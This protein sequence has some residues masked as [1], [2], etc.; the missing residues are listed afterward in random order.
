VV[1]N[2]SSIRLERNGKPGTFKGELLCESEMCD[3]AL[4]TVFNDA[5]WEDLPI[6]EFADEVPNLG[7]AVLAVGYP[8]GNKSVTVTR[9][10]VSTVCLKD[11]SLTGLNPRLMCVQIDAA[12]NPGNSGGP[13]ISIDSKKIIG[14]AFSHRVNASLMSFIISVPVLHMFLAAYDRDQRKNFGCLPETGFVCDEL[15]NV[16]HR[17]LALGNKFCAD[18]FYGC[19]V[20][21]VNKFSPSSELVNVGDVL[22]EVEGCRV[23]EN[24]EVFFRNQEWLPYDWLITK[25]SFGE[26]V[27]IKLLR[28][29]PSAGS[30][31]ML[32]LDIEVPL[33][34]IIHLVPKIL[35]VDL[36]PLWVIVG[37]LVFVKVSLPLIL[38]IDKQAEY[39]RGF[40]RGVVKIES[41]EDI[42]VVVDL[43]SHFVNNSYRK[44]KW[45]RLMTVNGEPVVNMQQLVHVIAD[46]KTDSGVSVR[47]F[48]ELDFLTRPNAYERRVAVFDVVEMVSTEREILEK[49]KIPSWCSLELLE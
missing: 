48:L 40:V 49:H 13:V 6:V 10:I 29:D 42:I 22:L 43:L 4:V 20:S 32:E 12:I 36:F 24:G 28:Q 47:R 17:K 19:V 37:G 1:R 46:A 39:L 18:N 7:D 27:R 8:L 30:G 16:S 38:Q 26:S 31:E 3:L 14:V 9:G 44:F 45:Q 34:P 11:L 2:A 25:K 23:S 5:F 15:K 35:G 41:N 33:S 21:S